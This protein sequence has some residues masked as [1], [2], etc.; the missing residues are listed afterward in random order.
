VTARAIVLDRGHAN[1]VVANLADRAA[2][3]GWTGTSPE[4]RELVRQAIDRVAPGDAAELAEMI[5][6]TP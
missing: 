5:G 2:C 4:D 6:V 1:R 3:D